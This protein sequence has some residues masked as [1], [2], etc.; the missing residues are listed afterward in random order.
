MQ[1]IKTTGCTA[2]KFEIDGKDYEEFSTEEKLE[3]LNK[4]LENYNKFYGIDCA[5]NMLLDNIEADETN[6]SESC[7]Q[8]GDYV[9]EQIYN[10][11]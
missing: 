2:Y 1:I 4:L 8:C 7:D 6:H 10:L 5:V 11:D 3:V 9:T